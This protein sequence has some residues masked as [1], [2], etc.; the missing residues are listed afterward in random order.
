MLRCPHLGRQRLR[1]QEAAD[2]DG[3]N[4]RLGASR[5]H[6]VSVTVANE[7]KGVAN[8]VGA[9]GTGRHARVVWPLQAVLNANVAGRKVDEHARDEERRDAA[10]FL[11]EAKRV[12]GSRHLDAASFCR[13]RPVPALARVLQRPRSLECC[14]CQRRLQR[15]RRNSPKTLSREGKRYDRDQTSPHAR[16]LRP[17]AVSTPSPQSLR[18]L[19]H[20]DDTRVIRHKNLVPVG[21]GN[22]PAASANAIKST[23]W[24]RAFLGLIQSLARNA[25]GASV[26][27]GTW[28]AIV[29]AKP[30]VSK[31]SMV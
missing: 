27:R 25:C 20:T 10:V 2:R 12:G 23:S 15:P 18:S 14:R 28:A 13:S 24:L 6:D 30:V 31:L 9:R 3:I 1:A 7:P 26:P 19:N 16:A 29:H 11:R 4:H 21:M 5:D 22:A 17:T 8:A